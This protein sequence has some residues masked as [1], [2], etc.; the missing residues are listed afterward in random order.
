MFDAYYDLMQT[1]ARKG[2]K[3]PKPPKGDQQLEHTSAPWLRPDKKLF[4]GVGREN[5]SKDEVT[6]LTSYSSRKHT[7]PWALH[8][9]ICYN[10]LVRL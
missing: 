8:D 4:E 9:S 2:V 6:R 5:M 1:M 3:K 10:G 7:D